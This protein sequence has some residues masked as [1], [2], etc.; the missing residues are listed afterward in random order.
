MTE[1]DKAKLLD[2]VRKLMA[3]AGSNPNEHEAA[4][5]AEK[6]QALLIEHNL[7]LSDIKTLN[8]DDTILDIEIDNSVVTPSNPWRR[9]LAL[10]VAQM[11]FCTYYYSVR[12]NNNVHTF[13]GQ[14]HNIDVAKMMFVYLE[15]TVKRLSNEGA[16]QFSKSEWSPYVVA[17]R[18]ACS[19]RLCHRILDRIEAAKRGEI[20]SEST[21]RALVVADLYTKT[22]NALKLFIEKNVGGMRTRHS[23]LSTKYHSQGGSDGYAAGGSIG[24]DGQV[25]GRA[26]H[27]QI[28]R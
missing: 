13:V 16:K 1:Q 6:A 18:N 14:R 12:G 22:Q 17:F 3:L 8:D 4:A 25:A 7:S 20:N 26:N 5:A 23:S 11:Y 9:P 2:R 19:V 15:K 27:K 24:L 21:G 10:R 28:G